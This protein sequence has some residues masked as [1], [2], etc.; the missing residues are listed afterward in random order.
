MQAELTYS[1]HVVSGSYSNRAIG[2]IYLRLLIQTI[3]VNKIYPYWVI[4]ILSTIPLDS[5]KAQTLKIDK[6][7]YFEI[8][9][10][11]YSN[12]EIEDKLFNY[13][14]LNNPSL[15]ILINTEVTVFD[16]VKYEIKYKKYNIYF[17]YFKDIFFENIDYWLEVKNIEYIN[18][19]KDLSVLFRTYNSSNT[20]NPRKIIKGEMHLGYE[21]NTF[22][23]SKFL[24]L[25]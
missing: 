21:D 24:L 5:I 3:G 22:K 2:H 23:I 12:V 10:L 14:Y 8:V 15:F 25:E 7:A 4:L 19:G 13:S 16:D 11:I 9:E 17:W 1:T 20:K 6:K 18:N